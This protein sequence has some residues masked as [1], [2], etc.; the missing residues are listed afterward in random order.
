MNNLNLTPSVWVVSTK[1]NGRKSIKGKNIYLKDS[2]EFK[3]ELHN[4]LTII[5]AAGIRMSGDQISSSLLVIRP[6]ERIYLD[7]FIDSK[8]KF[9][10]KTYNVDN[11]KENLNAINKNGDLEVVFYTEELIPNNPFP[12]SNWG[13]P[14][15]VNNRIYY[16]SSINDVTYGNNHTTLGD[17]FGAYVNG[18]LTNSTN[19]SLAS[20]TTSSNVVETGRVQGGDKSDQEFGTINGNYTMFYNSIKY[21]L[22]PESLKPIEKK[23][24]VKIKSDS[25]D[26]ENLIKTMEA[27]KELYDKEILTKEEFD[28]KKEEILK[29]I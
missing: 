14:H 18:S 27:L 15:Y 16:G 19:C 24:I 3:L 21:K 2:E 5:V 1:D 26:I 10:F 28:N 8:E 6:G 25:K 23:D 22:L 9:I 11:T 13:K 17:T 12:Y 7:C 20:V 4:P 29:R